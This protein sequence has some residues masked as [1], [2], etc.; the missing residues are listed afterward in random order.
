[1]GF[2]M[3]YEKATSMLYSMV[4]LVT[5]ASDRPQTTLSTRAH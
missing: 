2:L 3:G 4:L 1:M 5:V